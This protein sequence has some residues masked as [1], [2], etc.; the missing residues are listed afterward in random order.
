MTLRVV[1]ESGKYYDI[2]DTGDIK[3]LDMPGFVPSGQWKMLGM[4]HVSRN[5]YMTLSEIRRALLP[6]EVM[7]TPMPILRYKNGRG[8]WLMIDYDH[9]TRRQWGD[10]ISDI[11]IV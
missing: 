6:S 11:H 7:P 5:S 3:R 2:L 8:Q 10:R 1:T 4:K 9:G